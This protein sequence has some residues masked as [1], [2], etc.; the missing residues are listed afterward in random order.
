MLCQCPKLTPLQTR[1]LASV[2]A[3][4]LLGLIYW[5][6]SDAHFAYAAEL[7]FDGIGQPRGG[8][9]HNWHRIEQERLEG[10]EIESGDVE[11]DLAAKSLTARA[12]TASKIGGNDVANNDN[13]EPGETTFWSYPKQQLLSPHAEIGPGLPSNVK[14]AVKTDVKHAELRKRDT[15]SDEDDIGGLEARQ[16]GDTRTIYISI[17]TCLQP[18]YVGSGTQTGPPPQLTLYVARTASNTNPGPDNDSGNQSMIPLK[19]GFASAS[20]SASDDWYMSVHAPR[21]PNNFTGVWNYELG[22]SIDDYF[23]SADSDG[24][25]LVLLDSD[26]TAALL[27]TNN[28]TQANVSER[29]YREWMSLTAPYIIFASNANDNKTM[30]ISSSFCGLNKTSMIVG[31]QDDQN[32]DTTGVQ[33]RMI[34]RGLGHKPKEEFYV[35]SLNSSSQYHAVLARVGNSTNSGN[36][37]VG[38]GG[39]VWQTV[40]F[41]TKADGNCALLF[42]LSFCDEVAYAVPS[43]PDFVSDL[44]QFRYFYDNYTR[45]FY[46]HFNYSLQQIPCSTTSTAQY[47]LAKNCADCANA[48]KEWLCAVSIPRCEDFSKQATYLQPRNVG[49]AFYNNNTHL[50]EHYLNASYTPM[51]GAPTL[52]GTV[53]FSQTYNSSVATNQSRNPRIDE[54]IAPGPYKEVLPCEDLCYS[55]VQSCPAALG[56]GCPYPGRG[57]EAGYGTRHG[58]GNGTITCSYPGAYVYTDDGNELVLKA[59][60][61]IGAAILAVV[62]LVVF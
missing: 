51:P 62:V 35:T 2:V 9:D 31:K 6:L 44:S 56:F 46:H 16:N 59:W 42:N 19:E 41:P 43:T 22:I 32:G 48:Y 45:F 25:N 55:L 13:I 7:E 14:A 58:I 29:S 37:V 12:P 23:H 30:G 40:T 4:G 34:T 17:N 49:Q 33:M 57:L 28:L 26:S 15:E 36:G 1:F 38:G 5:S 18:N 21:L 10:D 60:R 52:E 24:P 8:E 20:I 27:M 3:L 54:V 39:K 53:A 61:A 50:P 47:S 11:R